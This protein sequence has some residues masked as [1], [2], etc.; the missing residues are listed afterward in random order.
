[1]STVIANLFYGNPRHIPYEKYDFGDHPWNA[2]GVCQSRVCAPSLFTQV[3]IDFRDMWQKYPRLPY[4]IQNFDSRYSKVTGDWCNYGDSVCSPSSG[5]DAILL[6]IAYSADYNTVAA[7]WT[8]EMI[9]EYAHANQT[10]R[11]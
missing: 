9:G 3:L 5:P 1:M 6:H 10:S 7:E 4:Q 8:L 2:T 11:K